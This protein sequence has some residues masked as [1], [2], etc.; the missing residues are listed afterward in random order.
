MSANVP[1]A[2]AAPVTLSPRLTQALKDMLEAFVAFEDATTAQPPLPEVIRLRIPRAPGGCVTH[3]IGCREASLARGR[4]HVAPLCT[5]K[6]DLAAAG[7]G[8]TL[9]GTWVG[10][11]TYRHESLTDLFGD[12][13]EGHAAVVRE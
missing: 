1:T 5:W 8:C 10:P 11:G 9:C 3:Q 12:P 7:Y 6:R 4:G 2:D 13:P